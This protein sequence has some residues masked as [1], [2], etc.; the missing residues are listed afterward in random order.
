M[1]YFRAGMII[2]NVRQAE[3]NCGVSDQPPMSDDL[4]KRLRQNSWLRPF[5]YGGK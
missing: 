4:E 5:W 1:T 2:R 3:M